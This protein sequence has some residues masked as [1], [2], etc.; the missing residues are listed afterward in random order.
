[1]PAIGWWR[2]KSFSVIYYA[3]MVLKSSIPGSG[4][5]AAP[6][7]AAELEVESLGKFAIGQIA[8]I[9][10]SPD[11]HVVLN[12]RSVSRNH[13]RLFYEGGHYWIKDLESANGTTV[14]GKRVTLQM[15]SSGDR[16]LFGDA[17]AVFRTEERAAGPARLA[18]DPLAGSDVAVPD[19]TP[20]GGLDGAFPIPAGTQRGSATAGAAQTTYA[21]VGGIQA[22]THK[23]ESLQAENER[24][25]A[26]IQGLRSAAPGFAA[27]PAADADKDE[28]ARLRALVTRLERAL[29]DTSLRLRNLQQHLDGK[30][31][32]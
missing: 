13:A 9:G 7:A 22:L 3:D 18:Q 8:T 30:T 23:I 26:E 32:S 25:R 28:I 19:G 29:A 24:L 21:G 15:L 12:L 6:S 5:M 1:M 27:A 10:R 31:R 14:N 2:C 4:N 11:S 20:T 17:A 16:I